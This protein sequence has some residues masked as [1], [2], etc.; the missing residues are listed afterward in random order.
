MVIIGIISFTHLPLRWIPNVNPPQVTVMTQYNGA[1]AR[2]IEKEITKVIEEAMSGVNGVESM[3]SSTHQGSSQVNITFK[4]GYNMDVAVD[5][6]RSNVERM[7]DSLPKEASSPVVLKADPNNQ[8]IMY[9]SFYDANRTEREM[10][11]YIDKFVAPVFE[12]MD[13]VGSV[14]VYGKRVTAMRVWL[15]PAKMAASRMTVGDVVDLLREQNITIPSGKIRGADRYYNVSTSTELRGVDQ[16]N[17][18]ILRGGQTDIVRL[19]DIG[20]AKLDPESVD[21]SFRVKGHTAIAIGITPQSTANP[22]EVETSVQKAFANIVKS[23]PAGMKADIAYNQ[24]DYIRASIKSVYESFIEAVI[25][26]WLVILVFLCSFRATLVPIITI[27]VCLMSSFAVLYFFGFSINT[28][29]L[30]AFVLAIGLVVDDAIVM[31]ENISRHIEAGMTPY[32]AAMQGS[33]E[34][35]FPIIAMTLTLAAV[36]APIAFTPGLLGVIF[37]EFT[38]TLAGAVII[39]GIVALTLSPMMCAKILKPAEKVN[40]YAVWVTALVDKLQNQYEHILNILLAKRKWVAIG[41]AVVGLFGAALY[42]HLPSELAPQE[43]MGQIDVYVGAPRSSS[44]TYTNSYVQQL[45]QMFDK[46]PDVKTYFS[47]TGFYSAAHGYQSLQLK[48]KSERQH[49]TAEIIAGL[50]AQT[51]SLTGVR[52]H[53]ASPMPPLAQFAGSDESDSLSMM[54]MT[55]GDYRHLQQIS[56]RFMAELK[57]MPQFSRVDNKLKWDSEEFQIDIDRDKAADLKVP[58]SSIASTISTLLASRNIGKT[59]DA[60]VIVQMKQSSLE[61]PNIFSQLYVRNTDG[62]VIP[63]SQFSSVSTVSAPEVF[64][65]Y[66]RLHAD[67]LYFTLAEGVKIADA[68]NILTKTAQTTLPDDVRFEFTG[69]AKSFLETAG[70]TLL[71]FGLALIF[72]YLVLVAQ[73]ESF[74]DPLVILLTVPFAVF[75]ALITLWMF[76]GTLNIYSNIGLITLIGLIAKHGILITEFANRM[77]EEGM[78]VYAAVIASSKLR[79]RPILMTTAAMILGALPL[80]FAFGPGAESRQQVGLVI[81]GGLFFGTFFSL[82]VIPVMYT[83]LAPLKRIRNPADDEGHAHANVL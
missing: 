20:E 83:Y 26:V 67:T 70:A 36:Y 9:L 42:H 14:S 55:T 57:K 79:L 64:H 29:T 13:G 16:F 2:I 27:P 75:G 39:S 15:D 78:D 32:A 62:L 3:T 76:G 21:D 31:L 74:I 43:D 48:P 60:N 4:L 11:D 8:P 28:I 23:L 73:F 81:T 33:K 46:I 61:N 41:L 44:F 59:D 30:M 18:L 5:D 52:V 68:I 72:I 45:E 6:V 58:V 82:I 51:N 24:A 47:V 38:F 54:L 12:T 49:T 35:I 1:N 37:R 66:A 71:T 7:R 65:R 25:F 80:A 10:S 77:R 56:E 63:M 40:A 34:M 19:K 22:L 69:Q 53:V 50:N 17:N